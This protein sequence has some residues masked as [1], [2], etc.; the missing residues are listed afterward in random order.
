M[1]VVVVVAVVVVAAVACP[2]T[3]LR[4]AVRR[5]SGRLLI[6]ACEDLNKRKSPS[7]GWAAAEQVLAVR[8]NRTV[9]ARHTTGAVSCVRPTPL[10]KRWW[11]QRCVESR[12]PGRAKHHRVT[13]DLRF[14]HCIIL[15]LQP[16]FHDTVCGANVSADRASADVHPRGLS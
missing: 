10:S 7:V 9:Q 14:V 3:M 15:P 5:C 16:A 8:V 2:L 12:S 4:V 11:H 6:G 13:F 1:V